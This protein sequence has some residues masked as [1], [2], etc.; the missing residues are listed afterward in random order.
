MTKEKHIQWHHATIT[1]GHRETQN[2]HKGAVLWLTGLSGAGKSTLAH[3]VEERLYELGCRSFVFDGDNV[4]HGLNK[5]LG[6]S[7]E[8][9]R[10]NI[11]RIGEVAKLFLDMGV[12]S[13]AAFISP[14]KVDR[15]YVRSLVGSA[16]FVELYCK[17]SLEK[18]ESRDVKGRYKA[19][20]AG[21]IPE[22]TG[23]SAPYEIPEAA[24]LEVDTDQ[25]PLDDCVEA[26]IE[27]LVERGVIPREKL[28]K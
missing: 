15:Q 16:D 5:D 21:A 9:R 8:A 14:Y 11:R 10:E 7:P 17:C 4:R 27:Y 1:R 13:L 22:F 6:F 25:K 20:R 23:I 3:A 24:E 19:A 18:C 12:I 28:M 2:G 26:V